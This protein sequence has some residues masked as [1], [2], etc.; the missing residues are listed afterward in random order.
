MKDAL[1]IKLIWKN[2]FFKTFRKVLKGK[3]GLKSGIINKH[4]F[5]QLVLD[6]NEIAEIQ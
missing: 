3:T 6:Q 1:D 2:G 5:D 4:N